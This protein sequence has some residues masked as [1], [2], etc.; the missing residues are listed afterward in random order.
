[1]DKQ[2][3]L[4]KA[5]REALQNHDYPRAVTSLEKV[6]EIAREKGDTGAV[7]RHLGNLALTHYR[8][9]NPIKALKYFEEALEQARADNDRMTENGLL[10]NMGN[11]LR[12][13]KRYDE[14]LSTTDTTIFRCPTCAKETL[15][16]E[17]RRVFRYVRGGGEL[18]PVMVLRHTACNEIAYFLIE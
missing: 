10:G 17:W 4:L 2:I 18:P 3:E 6:V 13:V 11:I 5:V 16:S 9:G 1:M 7:G 12:E 15:R 8:L 14:S